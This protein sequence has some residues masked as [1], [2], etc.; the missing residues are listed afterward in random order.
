MNAVV[1]QFGLPG[2]W[3]FASP[4]MLLWAIAAV[5]PV[6]IHL[7]SRRKYDEVPW[8]AMRFLLAAIRK[9]ARRWR[10]EQLILLA[11]RILILLLLAIA[12]ADPIVALLG[13]G[14][15]GGSHG[16]DTHS[17]VVIDA[18]YSMYYRRADATRFK[19]AKELASELVRRSLQG[20]GFTLVSLADPPTVVVREPVF[21]RESMVAE[22]AQLRRTDG[23]ADLT[24]TL[25]EVERVLDRTSARES[26]LRQ[27]RICIFT[28]LGRNTWGT[29]VG[30]EVRATLRRLAQKAELRL[31]DVGQSGGQNV[32][33]TRLSAAQGVATVG[34]P[35]RLDIEL[36]NVGN[37]D[38]PQQKV[39][40]L[41]DGQRVAEIEAN[42]SAGGRANVSAVHRFQTPG[43][44]VVE[45]R[46]NDDR[47]EADNRRWLSMTVRSTLEVLCVEG[48]SGSAHNVALA[49]EPSATL[50][51]HVRPVVR[52]EIALLEEDLTRY[53]CIFL[54]N[55][56][57]F[58]SDE[59]H[60][61]RRFLER[62]G[63]IV[64]FLGDQVQGANYNSILG[65]DAGTN[66]CFST[67][68]DAPSKLGEYRF[69]PLDYQHPV[70]KLF[71]G[72]ERS[73]LLTTPVW[74]YL[75]VTIDP[76]LSAT[77]AL[78]FQNGMPAIV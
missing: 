10:I 56:G 3:L 77:T 68:L 73:G 49:L 37:Q 63:G 53:D 15:S 48:K 35:I 5:V 8:A 70:V 26:R 52:S 51:T 24:A 61:L 67:R 42:V 32:A 44:H 71:R 66:R 75:N 58:G 16:G 39:Q 47:L 59:A 23:G 54:C 46:L 43:A 27:H 74:K 40:L 76:K 38:R 7:W 22:I 69:D 1:A 50:Q 29:V 4:W 41:V 55:V 36:E 20:D 30:E 31:F 28:D 45:A 25:A 2:I 11:I 12:L 9:N 65:P 60:L 57:R 17:I 64:V 14:A 6:L 34:A 78:A 72:H 21:D 13:D 19:A 18:S 62:G 33:L